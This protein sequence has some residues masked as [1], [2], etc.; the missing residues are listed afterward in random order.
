MQLDSARDRAAL[1][2]GALYALLAAAVDWKPFDATGARVPDYDALRSDP[3]SA[4]GAW[5][6]IEGAFVGEGEVSLAR[7]GPWGQALSFWVIKYGDVEGTD[8]DKIAVVL[9]V[10]PD[11][12]PGHPEF[13]Q[14]MRVP[15]AF[16]KVWRDQER[17]LKE[18]TDFV[19]FV[20]RAGDLQA[21]LAGPP[22]ASRPRNSTGGGVMV[23]SSWPLVLVILIALGAAWFMMRRVL[24]TMRLP[25]PQRVHHGRAERGDDE[26]EEESAEFRDDLPED[27]AEAML[28]LQREREEQARLAQAQPKKN[29]IDALAELEQTH[30][31]TPE[32]PP[33][34]SPEHPSEHPPQQDEP[35]PSA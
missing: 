11:G 27:P 17:T 4:R 15:A 34:H 18:P 32:H 19:T 5:F 6:L 7:P 22:P 14:P 8:G 21:A 33:E 30:H 31:T 29:P 9:L 2:E 10:D 20:A 3:V 16:F 24:K 13:K 25:V 23:Q 1:D 26:A 12:K 28:V 35:R